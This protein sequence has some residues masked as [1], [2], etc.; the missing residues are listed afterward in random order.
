MGEP[1]VS[2][3][4]LVILGTDQRGCMGSAVAM[5]TII[6]VSRQ[7]AGPWP[8]MFMKDADRGV[9]YGMAGAERGGGRRGV[10]EGGHHG[11]GWR[12]RSRC[13]QCQPRRSPAAAEPSLWSGSLRK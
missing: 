11:H 6:C 7:M 3:R 4:L 13:H 12:V 1:I 9:E 2:P 8:P 5:G 10:G